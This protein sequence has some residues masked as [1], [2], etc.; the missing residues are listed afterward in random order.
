MQ[1]IKLQKT[2]KDK[3]IKICERLYPKT[4]L[5]QKDIFI[6]REFKGTEFLFQQDAL[7]YEFYWQDYGKPFQLDGPDILHIKYLTTHYY[8]DKRAGEFKVDKGV[9]VDKHMHWYELMLEV[10]IPRHY[11]DKIKKYGKGHLRSKQIEFLSRT[12]DY[13]DIIYH[14]LYNIKHK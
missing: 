3:L 1:T 7:K 12:V 8:Y 9:Y 6:D 14:D 11:A 2:H 4:E 10:I 5:K 13:I